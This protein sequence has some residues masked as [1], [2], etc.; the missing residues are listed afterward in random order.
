MSITVNG[1][2]ISSLKVGSTQVKKVLVRQNESSEYTVVYVDGYSNI[3]AYNVV[4]V[5]TTASQK[6]ILNS[7]GYYESQ[8]KNI[9]SGWSL[10]K[11][12]FNI[13]GN[14]TLQC[15]SYGENNYDFGILSTIN[16]TLEASN[17]VDSTNV[18]KS[19][20][21]AASSSVQNVSY[22]GVK[23]GDY[24]YVKYRKDTSVNKYNDSLQFKVVKS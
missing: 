7:N 18:K 4:Q 5:S 20:K 17:K 2:P 8:C 13:A 11:V 14:Y 19:F 24:I 3:P 6:F 22:S 10:C 16:N 21:G 9:N 1:T 15:I 12:E 23:V